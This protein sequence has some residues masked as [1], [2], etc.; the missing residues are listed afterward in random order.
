MTTMSGL[1]FLLFLILGYLIGSISPGYFFGRLIKKIDLRDYGNFNTGATNTFHIVG[2][3][4]GIITVIIDILKT[5]LVYYISIQRFD[6]NLAIIFGL[7]AAI[8]HIAPFYLSFRGG[9]GIASLFGLIII[10]SF[11][12]NPIYVLMLVMG[13]IIY[14]INISITPIHISFRH[15]L[16]LSA[17]IFPLGLIFL[18]QQLI[19]T[20]VMILLF[21][22]LSFDILRLIIPRLN[23]KYLTKSDFAK[24]KEKKRFSGYT[25]FLAST[26]LVISFFSKEIAV[27][28]IAYFIIGDFFAPMSKAIQFLPQKRIL[29]DRTI[30]GAVTIFTVTLGTG[31]FLMSLTNLSFSMPIVIYG[32][33][34]VTFFDH[35]SFLVDDNLLVPLGT[36]LALSLLL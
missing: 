12:S 19:G 6:P 35:L 24:Q 14:A 26:F 25:L 10:A 23:K 1:Y 21:A 2:R 17:L 9:R 27:I 13:V 18:S 32:V 33:L 8:G 22:S 4:Y 20:I 29:Y 28:S 31:L 30:A 16:K 36:A 15:F 7:A 11:F 5:P 3:K 34:L